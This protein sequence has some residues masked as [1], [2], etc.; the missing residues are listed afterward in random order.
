MARTPGQHRTPPTCRW[1]L[2][3]VLAAAPVACSTPPEPEVPPRP[4]AAQGAVELSASS[5]LVCARMRAGDVR[6]W[7]QL[8]DDVSRLP[9]EMPGFAG[10]RTVHAGVAPCARLPSGAVQCFRADGSEYE[11][12]KLRGAEAL[13]FRIDHDQDDPGALMTPDGCARF[14]GNVWRCWNERE[15]FDATPL[16]GARSVVLS[17][18]LGCSLDARGSLRCWGRTIGD[19]TANERNVPTRVLDGVVHAAVGQHHACAVLRDGTVRCWGGNERGELGDGTTEARTAPVR[20]AGLHDA[21]EVALGHR[22]SCALHRD[23]G[24]SCW[25]ADHAGQLGGGT[26]LEHA[27]SETFAPTPRRVVEVADAKQVVAGRN[28]TC[29]LVAG[30]QVRCWGS[31]REGGLGN[32]MPAAHS[33]PVAVRWSWEPKVSAR[34][35]SAEVVEVQVDG[36]CS[37]ARLS[38]GT[39]RCWGDLRWPSRSDSDGLSPI[40][41]PTRIEAV[42]GARSLLGC[43]VAVLGD[44]KLRGWTSASAAP[45]P[46]WANVAQLGWDGWR[47]TCV[48]TNGGQV[49]CYE[50][51]HQHDADL[52]LLPSPRRPSVA[53][54][55]GAA[56]VTQLAVGNF[57]GC[58]LRQD[59]SVWCWGLAGVWPVEDRRL[60]DGPLQARRIEGMGRAVQV[61]V[62]EGHACARLVDRTVWCW[63][64]Q[65]L[66]SDGEPKSAAPSPVFAVIDAVDVHVG[67]A[68]SCAR[69]AGGNVVCWGNP[70]HATAP[71]STAE[72]VEPKPVAWL[73]GAK[74]LALGQR[75]SCAM[76]GGDVV[77]CWGDNEAGQLGDGTTAPREHLVDVRW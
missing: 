56:D 30:G 46:E 2:S 1:L 54:L 18:N 77:R 31:G 9:Q 21:V 35:A 55:G 4:R 76:F 34:L 44:G 8:G 22:H 26:N 59:G 7:G 75:H 53:P 45:L 28:F 17:P 58:A 70:G 47:Q 72:L 73:Q 63:G 40:I 14:A 32:G 39:V 27:S 3:A 5:S 74:G 48:L 60:P 66:G 29:A 15:T 16:A 62:G 12:V 61:A 64:G 6:C 67:V 13:S 38:D 42:S 37:C 57:G 33:V 69:S 49:R 65:L 51:Q 68:A 20:V 36:D 71:L 11:S 43:H 41:T 50:H 10:A 52:P 19:G 24:I 25:G 23:G